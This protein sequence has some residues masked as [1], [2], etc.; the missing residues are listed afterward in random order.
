MT[1]FEPPVRPPVPP[2]RRDTKPSY[3]RPRAA[4][5]R[6]RRVPVPRRRL[7]R[8][9][10]LLRWVVRWLVPPSL[11]VTLTT[12][13]MAASLNW[14]IPTE[15]AFM[16]SDHAGNVVYQWVPID[17]VSRNMIVETMAHEDSTFPTR[18][19]GINW[20]DFAKRSLDYLRHKD[21]DIGSTIPQQLT[22]NLWLSSARNPLRMALETLLT[23]ELAFTVSDR[24]QLE[25]Y[26]NFAQF[27]PRLY[28][29]CAA[30]WYYYDQ[31]PSYMTK[32][33]AARLTAILPGPNHVKRGTDG[34]FVPDQSIVGQLVLGYLGYAS[35]HADEWFDGMG[36]YTASKSIGVYGYAADHRA[37]R[38]PQSCST[39]PASVRAL[40]LG[41]GYAI[42][43]PPV[44]N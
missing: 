35:Q 32:L 12:T 6:P 29:I 31:P 13:L 11:G 10:R 41:N 8:L 4:G 33:Q 26:L 22:K 42:P 9:R 36:G 37:D 20:H 34:G 43:P 2:P 5:G 19:D 1:L 40:L 14:H 25:L 17:Y 44:L 39:M 38:S 30:S 28:G 23:E 7:R 15:S 21:D 18:I 3:E 27:G 24:R 16:E